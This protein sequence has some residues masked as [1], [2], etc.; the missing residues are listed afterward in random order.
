M[1][2]KPKKKSVG[3]PKKIT[4]DVIRGSFAIPANTHSKLIR[5]ARHK[6]LSLNDIVIEILED[7]VSRNNPV[8]KLLDEIDKKIAEIEGKGG[9]DVGRK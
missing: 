5:L 3:R 1:A 4:G 8:F 6:G 2:D 7:Y 9:D